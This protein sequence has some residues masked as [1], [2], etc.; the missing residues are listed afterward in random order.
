MGAAGAGQGLAPG[1]APSLLGEAAIIGVDLA[2]GSGQPET[3]VWGMTRRWQIRR[4]A[5][6]GAAAVEFAILLP[7]FLLVLGGITDWGRFFFTQ[8]QLANAAREGARAAVVST[9]STTDIE[10]RAKA[11]APGLPDMQVVVVLACPGTTATVE[12]SEDFEWILLGPALTLFNG[13]GLL[14]ASPLT[15]TA[16]MKCGG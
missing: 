12:T 14:P 9:A 1:G 5:E 2:T 13:A 7:L 15:S 16:V 4:I 8:I 10:D 6:R 11:A 3:G